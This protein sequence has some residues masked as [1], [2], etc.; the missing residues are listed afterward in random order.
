MAF[1]PREALGFAGIPRIAMTPRAAGHTDMDAQ[2]SARSDGTSHLQQKMMRQRQLVLKKRSEATKSVGVVA[3]Q[4]PALSSGYSKGK[5]PGWE[6][7]LASIDPD[8]PGCS[9]VPS[10]RD[11]T[12]N[13][14]ALMAQQPQEPGACEEEDK[15]EASFDTVNTTV[16]ASREVRPPLFA[17][18]IGEESTTYRDEAVPP[19]GH[20]SWDLEIRP[21]D[22]HRSK[23]E[24]PG[25]RRFWRPWG[26]AQQKT[27]EAFHDVD[28]VQVIGHGELIYQESPEPDI[29]EAEL[30]TSPV[31][32][33]GEEES[34]QESAMD[35]LNPKTN[36]QAPRQLDLAVA[37]AEGPKSAR[38]LWRPWKV[39]APDEVQ[40]LRYDEVDT[41]HYIDGCADAS[42]AASQRIKTPWNSAGPGAGSLDAELPGLLL[43]EELEDLANIMVPDSS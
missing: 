9:T 27:G 3:Q 41:V 43:D 34:S 17:E 5:V 32:L 33:V 31:P 10:A 40:V 36:A 2:L 12:D 22:L 29:Q 24:K 28:A 23:D 38:K 26:G 18:G 6:Q 15:A 35:P 4:H 14:H 16:D 19:R 1:T 37:G 42:A 13:R 21:E 39:D 8:S 30:N 7:F 20:G 11:V 25:G